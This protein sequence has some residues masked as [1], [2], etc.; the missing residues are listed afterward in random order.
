M[1][2]RKN[3][4]YYQYFCYGS[5][6][7]PATMKKLRGIEPLNAT[8]AVLPGYQLRF[9]GSE[10]SRLEP[11]AAFVVESKKWDDVVHGVIYTLTPEDFVKVGNTE[12]VPF[13]YRWRRCCVLPYIGVDGEDAGA[14]KLSD[15]WADNKVD[16]ITLISP[17]PNIDKDVPPS[18]SYLE[19]IRKGAKFWKLDASYQARLASTATAQNL[20]IPGG[21]SGPLLQLAEI[22]RN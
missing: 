12:G 14:A 1:V 4:D 10:S 16:A 18:S 3:D 19:I 21:L 11:S 17:K 20:I 13:G 6:V 5:N 8:A 15:S 9:D 22:L 2:V 7:L